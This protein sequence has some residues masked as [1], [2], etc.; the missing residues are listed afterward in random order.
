MSSLDTLPQI[1]VEGPEHTKF[2]FSRAVSMWASERNRSIF[3]IIINMLMK[4]KLSPPPHICFWGK[5]CVVTCSY[6]ELHV[7][8]YKGIISSLTEKTVVHIEVL[9]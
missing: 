1:S 8:S 7:I 3:I 5:H 2:D 6:V 9:L 4:L